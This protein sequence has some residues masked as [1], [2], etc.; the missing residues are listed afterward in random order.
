MNYIETISYDK[1]LIDA[2]HKIDPTKSVLF[3]DPNL[4]AQLIG[5]QQTSVLDLPLK[6][7]VWEE[8]KDVYIGFIDPKFMKK[9]F[10]LVGCDDIVE[11]LTKLMVRV[12]NDTIRK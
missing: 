6:I 11:A 12:T 3:E 5:C 2:G 7:L 4:S 9:R 8:H 10:L 1:T